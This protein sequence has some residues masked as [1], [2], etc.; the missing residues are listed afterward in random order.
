MFTPQAKGTISAISKCLLQPRS[1]QHSVCSS[2]GLDFNKSNAI[3]A[4]DPTPD[5]YFLKNCVLT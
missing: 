1:L 4:P 3:Y 5:A 2:L